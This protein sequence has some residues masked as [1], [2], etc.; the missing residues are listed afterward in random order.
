MHAIVINT[1]KTICR[2][3]RAHHVELRDWCARRTLLYQPIAVYR[4]SRK[5]A[6][7]CNVL[8]DYP[9]TFVAVTLHVSVVE[10]GRQAKSVGCAVRTIVEMRLPLIKNGARG[11]PYQTD[12]ITVI[13][14]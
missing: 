7:H 13:H 11:A 4:A 9:L 5:R 12:C 14:D 1:V 2:V 6:T 10:A 3:R 8:C